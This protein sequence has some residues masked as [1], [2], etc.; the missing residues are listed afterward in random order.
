MAVDWIHERERGPITF[1]RFYKTV[2][3]LK[4]QL[5][6]LLPFNICLLNILKKQR[7]T[8]TL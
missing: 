7:T 6:V 4:Q 5:S 3:L 2:A 1:N 8:N